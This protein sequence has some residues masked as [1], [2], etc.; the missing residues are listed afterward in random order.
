[1]AEIIGCVVNRRKAK[2]IPSGAVCMPMGLLKWHL[3][4]KVIKW[5]LQYKVTIYAVLKPLR[6]K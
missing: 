6:T 3:Q 4:Y 2:I 1:M 5:H